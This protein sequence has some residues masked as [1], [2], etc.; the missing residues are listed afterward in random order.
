V[1]LT[2][3]RVKLVGWWGLWAGLCLSVFFYLRACLTDPNVLEVLFVG[4]GLVGVGAVYWPAAL[5]LGAVLGVVA[6][7]RSS[8]RRAEDSVASRRLRTV[9]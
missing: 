8:Q 3:V 7:E 9:A 1:D 6:C 5:I 4:A 2:S